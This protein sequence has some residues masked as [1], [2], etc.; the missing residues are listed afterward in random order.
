M[1]SVTGVRRESKRNPCGASEA[2]AMDRSLMRASLIQALIP[3]AL[4]AVHDLLEEEVERLAGPRYARDDDRPGCY[5]WGRQ[6]GSVY[7]GDQKVAVDVP[8]VRNV[9]DRCEIPLETYEQL[10]SPH[11]AD[12]LA[13]RR[14]LH[15]LSCRDY[16]KC[17]APLAETFGLSASSLSRKFRR[18]S[19]ERLAELQERDLSGYDL[20]GMLL[21]G[22][23]FGD[24]EM[25]MA[26]GVTISGEKVVLGFVQTA[27]ENQAVCTEF[28]R[29]L[30]ARGLRYEQ[31]LLVVMD[32]ARG[33][34]KAV[35]NVLGGQTAVQR[36]Q[37]HKRENVV[38]YLPKSEQP[39]L[40]RRLQ[41]AYERPT[42]EQA[43]RE[44]HSIARSLEARHASAAASLREGLE[45]TLTVHRLG[46]GRDLR[47]SFKTTNLIENMNFLLG[48]RTDKVDCWKNAEQKHRW[49]ASALLEIE[50]RFHRIKGY[51]V[52]P[53]LRQALQD[54]IQQPARA[55]NEMPFAN[56]NENWH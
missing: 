17:V 41:R 54:A 21:D 1:C 20:V 5:R 52:L 51:R 14:L 39:A 55:E 4:E 48:M 12:E 26:L 31:G 37:W 34:R 56:F 19:A 32:G 3:I 30:V 36:C 28:L 10:Q 23:H 50:A 15:G 27:T 47:W 43:K 6:C 45:E 46:L 7:L 35:R 40:R 24:D 22:K 16:S 8:R 53:K 29:G 49:L 42:Y 9:A 33:L 25:V 11:H 44:L 13:F 2:V 38:R 18:R